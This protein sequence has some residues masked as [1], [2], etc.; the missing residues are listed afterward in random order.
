MASKNIAFIGAPGV[1]K[2][3]LQMKVADMLDGH[4][5]H[6]LTNNIESKI[7]DSMHEDSVDSFDIYQEIDLVAAFVRRAEML[8]I[9]PDYSVIADEWVL[10]ELANTM[11]KMNAMQEKLKVA[12]QV[13]GPDGNPIFTED[14]GKFIVMQ[15]V[16]QVLLN[17]VAIEKD[18]WDFLYYVPINDVDYDT[19]DEEGVKPKDR[20]HQK[21]IDIALQTLIG[22]LKLDVVELPVDTD[23]SFKILEGEKRKWTE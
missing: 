12:A 20:L 15:S 18:F 21:E 2:T 17:Q 6:R 10:Q 11:V 9:G 8:S 16:F 1:D 3:I 13:L 7:L 19:V 4:Y 5:R 23:K 22:Q 14:Y